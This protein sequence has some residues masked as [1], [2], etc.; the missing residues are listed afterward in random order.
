MCEEKPTI[1]LNKE[2]KA[3]VLDYLL[4]TAEDEAIF[5]AFKDDED[6]GELFD[7]EDDLAQFKASRDESIAAIM[8]CIDELRVDHGV[9]PD[10]KLREERNDDDD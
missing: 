2:Q 4:N 9:D 3:T 6:F 7:H 5:E 1:K 10:P 8:R